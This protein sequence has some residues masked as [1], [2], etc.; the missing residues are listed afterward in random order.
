MAFSKLTL[1][2]AHAGQEIT[3]H[4]QA[5]EFLN[6]LD[7]SK[8][9]FPHWQKVRQGLLIAENPR[10]LAIWRGRNF[11]R[12]CRLK[13]GLRRN[14]VAPIAV[15]ICLKRKSRSCFWIIS[16]RRRHN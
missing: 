13:A 5:L 8:Q 9:S 10:L 16:I 15:N 6:R 2:S 11:A 4:S 7:V 1:S 3:S 14:V 12:L